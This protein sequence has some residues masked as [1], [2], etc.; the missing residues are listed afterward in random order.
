[1]PRLSQA[2]VESI[3]CTAEFEPNYK[4]RFINRATTVVLPNLIVFIWFGTATAPRINWA[5]QIIF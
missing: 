1:M 3:A 4:A 2:M 5:L